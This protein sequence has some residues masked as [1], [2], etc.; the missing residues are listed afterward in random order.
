MKDKEKLKFPSSR[1]KGLE[2]FMSFVHEPRWKPEKIDADLFKKLDI[3]KGKEGLAV[4]AIKFLG[5]ID[6][7]GLPTSEF[8]KLKQDYQG[9]MKRLVEEN[10]ASLLNILPYRMIN[11]ARL[12]KFFGPPI[13]TAEYQSKLFV[14]FCQQANIDLP[15]VESKFHRA[16]FDKKKEKN[17]SD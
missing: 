8:D 14:W 4:H 9:T 12:V 17:K 16:R 5:I 2:E 13:E 7:E 10:Y 3:A 6:S 1:L 15:N 11:Q